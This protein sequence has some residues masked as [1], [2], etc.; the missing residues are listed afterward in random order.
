MPSKSRGNL[1][2]HQALVAPGR[3]TDEIGALRHPAIEGRGDHLTRYGRDMEAAVAEIDLGLQVV[4]R[5]FDVDRRPLVARIRGDAGVAAARSRRAGLP[6]DHPAPAA[7]SHF[8]ELP[9][10]SAG[11]YPQLDADV[12]L[13]LALD[14]AI[15][16]VG[17]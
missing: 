3:A 4:L 9:V 15:G 2:R 1:G 8:D 14:L 6:E 17:A 16:G 5:P 10:P 11:G 13:D 12:R 7:A